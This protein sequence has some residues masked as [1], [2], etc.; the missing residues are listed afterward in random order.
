MIEIPKTITGDAMNEKTVLFDTKETMLR[1]DAAVILREL[2]DALARGKFAGQA[3]DTPVG[4][5]LKVEI[6]GKV[7]PKPEGAKGEIKIELSWRA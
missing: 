7:K 5:H 6:K 4:E 3:G 2:A 1:Y